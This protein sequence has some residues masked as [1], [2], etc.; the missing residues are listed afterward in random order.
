LLFPLLVGA[1][2]V[3]FEYLI[4][5]ERLTNGSHP[6]YFLF[7]ALLG[8]TACLNLAQHLGRTDLLK[9]LK[10]LGRYSLPIY[11]A[12]M[13]AGAGMRLILAE[14]FHIQNWIV[15]ITL[16][17]TVALTVPVLLQRISEWL[18]FPYLFEFPWKPEKP[19]ANSS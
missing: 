2:Y 3:T 4:P 13:L 15:H 16:G 5:P 9:P 18:N 17:V 1:G 7:L 10:V 8:M 12:H 19:P 11:L 6:F 14:I